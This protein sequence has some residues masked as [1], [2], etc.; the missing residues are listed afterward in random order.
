M[1]VLLVEDEE[2]LART[3][4]RGLVEEGHQV[5]VCAT[6]EDAREQLEQLDYDVVVL[7]WMLPG[8]DG[9]SIL[10]GWRQRG[11]R[12]PVLMLTARSA[13]PE[14]VAGLRAGADDFLAKPFDFEE[15]LARLEAL[16]RRAG[17]VSGDRRLGD[18][19]LDVR[20][21]LLTGPDDSVEL[22][23]REYA[24]CDRLFERAGDV[25]TRTELLTSI[26]GPSFD[27]EP[28]VVDVYV[29]YVRKKI[30]R[31]GAQRVELRT[32]R[33]VGFRLVERPR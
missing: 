32:V 23:A 5:D 28:N 29:G 2:R 3:V 17:D 31:T 21:R 30:A 20:R 4:A 15:L 11:L 9:L 25:L 14:R 19:E 16:H 12:V 26:W 13:V 7:D 10:R 33:G 22:T 27:G 8:L 1:R 6:G 18:L 24:L